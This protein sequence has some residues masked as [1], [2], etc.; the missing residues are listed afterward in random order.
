MIEKIYIFSLI[1]VI[2][3]E[4]RT[5]THC[6]GLGHETMVSA[7]RLIIFLPTLGIDGSLFVMLPMFSHCIKVYGSFTPNK[8]FEVEVEEV[9]CCH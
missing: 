7:V 2:K 3:S 5:I 9:V 6:W 1:I 4:V 8:Y